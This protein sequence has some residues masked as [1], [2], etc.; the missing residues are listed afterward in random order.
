MLSYHQK[1]QTTIISEK[2]EQQGNFIYCSNNMTS[3]TLPLP[4]T[5]NRTSGTVRTVTSPPGLT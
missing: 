4:Q 2:P 3:Q 1:T 5:N